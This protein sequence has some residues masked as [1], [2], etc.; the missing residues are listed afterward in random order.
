V[1]SG[2]F[3]NHHVFVLMAWDKLF[4]Y[5]VLGPKMVDNRYDF[6]HACALLEKREF[7][8]VCG[9]VL[10]YANAGDSNAQCLMGFLCQSGLGVPSDLDEAERWLR[11]AAEQDNAVAWNN[12]G[13]LLLGKGE[14]QR[15]KECYRRAVELGLTM[16]A[17]LAE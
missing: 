16:S 3:T 7:R 8:E 12:L 15:S 5:A 9:Y 1:K 13:T 14:T 2:F 11:K 10:P 17:L 4:C 6:E